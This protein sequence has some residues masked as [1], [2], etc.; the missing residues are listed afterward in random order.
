MLILLIQLQALPK[1]NWFCCN[2]CK[3]INSSLRKIVVHGEEKLP[4]DLLRIIKRRYG[5]KGLACSENH[6]IKWRLLHGRSASA[7]EARSLLSQALSLLH[8]SSC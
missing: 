7:A 5:R 4:D 3:S 1:G 2:D 8:V 6:E